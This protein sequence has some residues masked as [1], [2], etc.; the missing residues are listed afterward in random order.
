MALAIFFGK[1][2][3]LKPPLWDHIIFP[4]LKAGASQSGRAIHRRLTTV[5]FNYIYL[6]FQRL[7]WEELF[8][9][10][11]LFPFFCLALFRL[12]RHEPR[13][14]EFLIEDLRI[15]KFTYL[16]TLIFIYINNL[17]AII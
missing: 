16:N 8:S 3:W 4:G 15:I 5:E 9:Q 13:L 10:S 6:D 17:L 7:V 14:E 1:N 11:I 12:V 2:R